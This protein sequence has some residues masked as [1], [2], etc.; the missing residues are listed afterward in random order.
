MKRRFNFLLL[1]LRLISRLSG[2][3]RPGPRPI[4]AVQQF[5]AILRQI[6][7][8]SYKLLFFYILYIVQR[9][10]PQFKTPENI[11]PALILYNQSSIFVYNFILFMNFNPN[12]VALSMYKIS[13]ILVVKLNCV[14]LYF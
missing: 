11:V 12:Y 4:H 3:G 7:K 5:L 13:Q 9:G 14:Y 8:Q 2:V 1:S 6:F 10:K